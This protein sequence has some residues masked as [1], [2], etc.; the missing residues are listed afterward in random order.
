MPEELQQVH[1]WRQGKIHPFGDMP[2]MVIGVLRDNPV[3]LEDRRRQ[4]DDMAS[5]STNGKV[6]IHGNSGDI[7]ITVRCAVLNYWA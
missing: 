7:T 5:L 4:L 6:V 1:N 2:V 3:N